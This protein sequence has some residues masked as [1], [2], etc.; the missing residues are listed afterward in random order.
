MKLIILVLKT[1]EIIE[2]IPKNTDVLR[3]FVANLA[4]MN[5][6]VRRFTLA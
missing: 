1:P 3:I 5:V 6:Q 2:K 4:M